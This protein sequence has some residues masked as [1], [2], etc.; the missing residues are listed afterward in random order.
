M[1]SLA[2]A[3]A[4]AS[5]ALTACESSQ[6]KSAKLEKVIKREARETARQQALARQSLSIARP[7]AVVKVTEAKLVHGSEGAVVAVVLHN[8][9]GSALRKLPI[10]VT[11]KGAGGATVYTN[12]T[13]GLSPTLVSVPLL[14]AH[15]TSTWIDD[16]VQTSA[17]PSSVSAE[18]GE[19]ERITGAPP[20]L[21]IAGARLAAGT[22]E[23]SVT[24][25][26]QESQHELVVDAVAR[27]GGTIVAAGRAVIPQVE[28]GA[29]EH[30]QAFLIGD[31]A[32]ATLEV[33][34]GGAA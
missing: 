26:S 8:T 34:V 2:L 16:Q 21:T 4:L 14:R 7:S 22:T 15:A 3:L 29:T 27:R 12:E 9:S 31:S 32:G 11:V 33:S 30:F 5:T 1:R 20:E 10:R 24:N 13:T 23:G 18:V 19:G 6:E 25:N 28:A 17:T